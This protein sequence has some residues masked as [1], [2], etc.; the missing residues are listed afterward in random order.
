MGRRSKI[1]VAFGILAAGCTGGGEGGDEDSPATIVSDGVTYYPGCE[2]GIPESALGE[3]IPI[4]DVDYFLGPGAQGSTID[5]FDRAEVIAYRSDRSHCD[6]TW[7]PATS[8]LSGDTDERLQAAFGRPPP[9]G[10]DVTTPSGLII[11]VGPGSHS[12]LGVE[13]A[14]LYAID[15]ASGT[16]WNLTDAAATDFGPVPSSD[17]SALLFRRTWVEVRADG[18]ADRSSGIFLMDLETRRPRQLIT[19]PPE[20]CPHAGMTWS[21]EGS[22]FA[23]VDRRGVAIRSVDEP[24]A[25]RICEGSAC[26]TGPL[27]LTWSPDGGALAWTDGGHSLGSI[28][29]VAIRWAER[30]ELFGYNQENHSVWIAELA[31]GRVREIPRICEG[32]CTDGRPVWSPNG[33][34]LAFTRLMRGPDQTWAG[35]SLFVV[36]RSDHAILRTASCGSK[37]RYPWPQEGHDLLSWSG[38][39]TSIEITA[40]GPHAH[41]EVYLC[42]RPC[43]GAH[44]AVWSPD[45]AFIAFV[46][47]DSQDTG[48]GPY[49]VYTAHVELQDVR[50]VAAHGPACCWIA[51][52][53]RSAASLGLFPEDADDGHG[54]EPPA[55][56]SPIDG[57]LA[58]FGAD[59]AS[60]ESAIYSVNANGTGL[61][62]LIAGEDVYPCCGVGPIWSPDGERILFYRNYPT[63]GWLVMP[64]SGGPAEPMGVQEGGAFS[65]DG[66]RLAYATGES[67]DT[68]A[69]VI[70]SLPDGP[71]R[72]IPIPP[73]VGF[74]SFLRW[75]PDASRIAFSDW[76]P[77]R[78]GD[79]WVLDVDGGN[80]QQVT[81]LPGSEYD[82][83][84]S[85]DGRQLVF[86]WESS[87]GVDIYLVEPDGGRPRR[88][89]T[90]GGTNPSFSP[91]GSVVAFTGPDPAGG[92]HR[93]SIFTIEVDGGGVYVVLTSGHLGYAD[94]FQT[95]AWAPG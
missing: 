92:K 12:G 22:R 91:D 49:A 67:L 47:G 72:R 66:T 34:K 35:Q 4:D 10:A 27:D 90:S 7:G 25:T 78:T 71:Q 62:K 64:A 42:T 18:S 50:R 1:I 95:L 77:D 8:D 69:L 32:G 3:T 38:Y 6:E 68:M 43:L 19:C 94:P 81:D 86:T 93:E 73:E 51:W 55:D 14:E 60:G 37:C 33:S 44:A 52:I 80:L 30:P 16:R 65:P 21:P 58:F 45:D 13:D 11:S 23:Y 28:L 85:P 29:D 36:R 48:D 74:P 61:R 57:R 39:D 15:P 56:A 24:G 70:K 63:E 89:T 59:P 82:V 26:G 79:V 87:V 88:L 5:G 9:P 17:G 75:S 31:S 40:T 46:G 20:G 41:R 76:S 83:D 2:P 54:S 53:D 84:W